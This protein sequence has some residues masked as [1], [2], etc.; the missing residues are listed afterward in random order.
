[1]NEPEP[2]YA[3]AT[4]DGFVILSPAAIDMALRG[5]LSHE[6][7]KNLWVELARASAAAERAEQHLRGFDEWVSHPLPGGEYEVTHGGETCRFRP[8]VNSQ[9]RRGGPGV[10][11]RDGHI[12]TACRR[13]APQGAT[14]YVPAQDDPRRT[15]G[16]WGGRRL[17]TACVRPELAAAVLGVVLLGSGAPS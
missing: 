8:I 15:R 4:P 2:Q 9:R 13:E 11:V 12:C 14:M 10:R 17:C 7:A 6:E 5:K 16:L 3:R 1:M